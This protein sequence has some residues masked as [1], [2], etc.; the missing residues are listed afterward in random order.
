MSDWE[1][2]TPFTIRRL[3][4]CWVLRSINGDSFPENGKPAITVRTTNLMF[5]FPGAQHLERWGCVHYCFIFKLFHGFLESTHALSSAT[6]A[7]L[8]CDDINEHVNN[9][10]FMIKGIY[11]YFKLLVT[12]HFFLGIDRCRQTVCPVDRLVTGLSLDA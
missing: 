4:I 9:G 12:V 8:R 7:I 3:R 6:S 5:G 1:P 11:I 10:F 2:P